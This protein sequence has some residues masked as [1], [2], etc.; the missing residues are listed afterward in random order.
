[1]KNVLNKA[2][3]WFAVAGGFL[4]ATL[5]LR[6]ERGSAA[7][8]ASARGLVE[9]AAAELGAGGCRCLAVAFLRCLEGGPEPLVR[10]RRGSEPLV[11]T[12]DGPLQFVEE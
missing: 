5:R 2:A 3:A 7:A 8:A 6:L 4:G 9:L 1:M 12:A 11:E 10:R